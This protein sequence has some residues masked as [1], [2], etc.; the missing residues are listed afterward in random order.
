MTFSKEFK[1]AI[2]N[3]PNKEKDKLILRLLKKDLN[4]ANR[5][6]FELLDRGT[7]EE[8]RAKTAQKIIDEVNHMTKRFYSPGY[9]NMDV[10]YASGIINEHVNITKD[11]FGEVSLNILLLTQVIQK[12]KQNILSQSMGR[13]N[14]LLVAL[15]A[16]AFK[17]ILLTQKL[18][19][20]FFIDLEDDLKQLG[21]LIGD[22]DHLM[23]IA[24]YHGFDVNWLIRADI[25]QDIQHIYKDLR[26]RGYLR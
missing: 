24:I 1:E 16:R 18:H 19:E 4:L 6:E 2:A 8:R 20:D 25:P 26:E 21:H 13:A 11:K 15:I 12:N 9:L 22:N 5:L 14:K 10:R 3:L 17:I 7:I 23:Q